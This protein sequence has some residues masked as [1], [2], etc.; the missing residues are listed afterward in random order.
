MDASSSR[1]R[2]RVVRSP[3]ASVLLT[4]GVSGI[5]TACASGSGPS[6]LLSDWSP[7]AGQ[8]C[9][10]ETSADALPGVDEVVDPDAVAAELAGLE[11]G[12]VVFSVRRD[13]LGVWSPAEVLESD[14][15]D[16]V[17]TRVHDAVQDRLLDGPPESL[18]LELRVDLEDPA[19][20]RV[21][22]HWGCPPAIRNRDDVVRIM[23]EVGQEVGVP[24]TVV[25]RMFVEENGSVSDVE[26]VRTSGI[27][28][29][30]AAMVQAAAF[31]RFHP[32]VRSG[33]YVP[34]WSQF[35]FNITVR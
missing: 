18:G 19:R 6:T 9:A 29:L 3:A 31:V 4:L 5:L 7:P 30:D 25:L 12:Y 17:E 20:V 24:G 15:A 1:P 11:G 33:R 16:T 26:V 21:G 23:E 28:A 32:A 10:P 27:P 14:V 35:P 34:V 8:T 22:P 13:T 2:R